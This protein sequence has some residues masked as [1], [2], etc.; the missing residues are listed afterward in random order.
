MAPIWA[1]VAGPPSPMPA[2]P[3]TVSIRYASGPSAAPRTVRVHARTSRKHQERFIPDRNRW[4]QPQRILNLLEKDIQSLINE[5]ID[6]GTRDS[7]DWTE[8]LGAGCHP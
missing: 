1:I 3:A 6:C 7:P 5:A 8:R 4:L 2:L